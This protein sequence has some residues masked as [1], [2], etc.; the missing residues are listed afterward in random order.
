MSDATQTTI[1]QASA[2]IQRAAT[3]LAF[4][5]Q[6]MSSP[7]A[8]LQSAGIEIPAGAQVRAVEVSSAAA[9]LVVPARPSDVSDSDLQSALSSAGSTDSVAALGELFAKSWSDSGLKS[10][11]TQNAAT[12][13]GAHGISVP[14]GFQLS[15]VEATDN[16]LYVT[17]PSASATSSM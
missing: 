8:A 12:T 14:S 2:V 7:A 13:L 10:S 3:D 5:Q 1:A 17:V 15:T 9:T 16:T 6:L 11:L 4:R